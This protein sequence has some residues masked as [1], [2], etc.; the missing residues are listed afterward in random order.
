MTSASDH[1]SDHPLGLQHFMPHRAEVTPEGYRA[2]A[3][4]AREG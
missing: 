4:D 3:G 2:S 1:S